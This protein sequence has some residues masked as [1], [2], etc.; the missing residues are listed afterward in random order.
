MPAFGEVRRPQ[1]FL[2]CFALLL[3]VLVEVGST[4]LVG[5][6]GAGPVAAVATNVPGAQ[7]DM[8]DGLTGESPPGNGIRY[9]AL[10]DGYLL[11][12]MV[13]LALSFCLSQ[14]LYG[15][16]QGVVTLVV[17][18]LWIIGAVV[19]A[20]AAF[21]LLMEMF[22]L[23]VSSPFGTI[24]YLASWGFFPVT[25]A[26]TV[27]GLLLIL[28][29]AFL[30]LLVFAQQ[31]FLKAIVLMVHIATS[32]VLQLVLGIVHGWLP[33]IVVSLGDQLMALL[34]AV[35]SL[36]G[37]IWAFVFSIPAVVNAIRVSVSRT[38]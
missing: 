27:L 8:V 37:A 5:G 16:L 10:V 1:F 20:L 4:T 31:R 2:A 26:A 38:Q 9:L 35:V 32:F 34:F 25:R 30:V 29:L 11:F 22:G 24:V 17:S 12:S 21:G 36:A 6:G 28:K 18:L 33:F 19:A 13:M 15:R 7:P 3:V 23:L 14:R